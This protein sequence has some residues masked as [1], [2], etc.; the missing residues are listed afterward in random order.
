MNDEAQKRAARVAARKASQD[1]NLFS[2]LLAAATASRGQ[3]Q[4]LLQ[5]SAGLSITEWRI[6]WDLNEA[7]P[8]SVQDMASI[9]RTDHS[10]I[11]RALPAMRDKGL[12]KMAPNSGDKRQSLVEMTALG[13]RSFA[14]AAPVMAGR[15]KR[16][17][18]TFT[19]DELTQ[20]FQLLDRFE[21]YLDQPADDVCSIEDTK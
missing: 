4:R 20:F 14:S 21:T 7:A 1:Q 8:L 15:R 19:A 16:L 13:A 17:A 10:L 9:Q 12:V 11:S 6:L 5:S 2:R 3:A 18:N